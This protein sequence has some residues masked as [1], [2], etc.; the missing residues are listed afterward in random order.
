MASKKMQVRVWQPVPRQLGNTP[1]PK[2]RRIP[3]TIL[4]VLEAVD[5]SPTATPLCDTDIVNPQARKSGDLLVIVDILPL[6]A[7]SRL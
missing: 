5:I 2:V 4:E 6:Q 1:Q 7:K 3:T